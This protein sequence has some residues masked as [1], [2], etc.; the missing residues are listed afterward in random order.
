M[1][2]YVA[3]TVNVVSD[4][5]IIYSSPGSYTLSIPAGVQSINYEII[6]AGGDNYYSSGQ[7]VDRAGNGGYIKG[8]IT[9]PANTSSV[10]IIVDE[11][12]NEFDVQTTP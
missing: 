2:W 7:P 11:A 12:G 5:K 1:A 9:L 8:S 3:S 6:G 4:E 10:D